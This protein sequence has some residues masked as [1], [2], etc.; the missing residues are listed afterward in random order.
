MNAIISLCHF[1]ELHG[2]SVLFCTQTFHTQDPQHVLSAE[3]PISADK[4]APSYYVRDRVRS[5]TV[6]ASA[7]DPAEQQ[8]RPS[9][10]S[11]L[12]EACRSLQPDQPGFISNDHEAK[13][14]YVSSQYPDHPQV[15]SMVRQACLRSLSCEVCPGRE[16]PIFFGDDHRGHVFSHTFFIQDSQARGF[17]RWYSIV[18]AMMDKVYLLNSWPFLVQHIKDIIDHI[19]EKASAVYQTEQAKCP[20]RA[21]RLLTAHINPA[22]FRQHR[23]EN[24]PARSLVDLTNDKNI[25][26]YLHLSFTWVLKACGNRLTEKLV[27]GPPTE[28]SVIDLEKQEETDEG[29]IKLY[30]KKKDTAENVTLDEEL[31]TDYPEPSFKN[32]RHLFKTLDA[33]KFHTLAHHVVTGNQI[34]VRSSSENLTRSLISCL[35]VLL[36]RGCCSVKGYSNT[37]E[38]SWRCNFL[39]IP[40]TVMMPQHVVTSEHYLL[41]EVRGPLNKPPV[42]TVADFEFMLHS[43]ATLPEKGPT[44]LTKMESAITNEDLPIEVVEQCLIC[45]KEEWMNK[46]KVLFMFTKAGGSRSDEDNK[47]MLKVLGAQEEDKRVLKFWMTGLSVQYRNH[48]LSASK[49]QAS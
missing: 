18:V 23:G 33:E 14:S 19:Q 47:K 17:S 28:D 41:V 10:A 11:D 2:P 40:K 20:Q 9:K 21:H 13:V 16:G 38:D 30:T 8:T 45:L 1:C 37:Y 24:K 12:C 39:G 44:V 27:E 7:S 46:V 26:R 31:T 25:F 29:F 48:M 3:S 5:P 15:F 43:E 22:N 35:K 42:P 6:E 34:V 4:E 36:P 32:I 49:S